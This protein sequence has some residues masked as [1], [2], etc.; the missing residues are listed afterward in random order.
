MI[1]IN[2]AKSI[3]GFIAQSIGK[4]V[5]FIFSIAA[6]SACTANVKQVSQRFAMSDVD[7]TYLAKL[8]APVTLTQS[9]TKSGF[10]LMHSG[11]DALASIIYLSN[12]A[13]KSLDLQY[14][15]FHQDRSG[16]LVMYHLLKAADRGVKVRLLLDDFFVGG[17]NANFDTLARHPNIE[18]KL[19]NPISRRKWLRSFS[20]L[21]NFKIANRR[22]HNK[23]FIAD[24][25][26]AI[27]GGRN[28]G[29]AYYMAKKRYFYRDLDLLAIGSVVQKVSSSFDAY[30]NAKWAVDI[31]KVNKR[32]IFS[33][34]YRNKRQQ[35]AQHYA[36]VK[37]SAYWRHVLKSTVVKKLHDA[38]HHFVWAP[39]KVLYDPPSKVRRFRK[40]NRQYIEYLM[41]QHM[42]Q[43]KSS[44]KIISPYFVP[45]WSGMRWIKQLRKKGVDI[46]V[47]TNS[48]AANDFS[49]S[50]GAY[51]RYRIELLKAGVKLYEFKRGALQETRKK[52]TW[53][54]KK[55]AS[56]LHAKSIIIDD[57]FVYVGSVNYT[58][59]SKLLNT[60]ISIMIDSPVIASELTNTF[61]RLS[62]NS[63]SY[64]LALKRDY[65]DFEYDEEEQYSVVWGANNR[66]TEPEVGFLKHLSISLLSL[67]PIEN[68]L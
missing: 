67:L 8:L 1:N 17:G 30:W 23:V 40:R 49:L 5:I 16:K 48:F 31:K 18:V 20:M 7:Q 24:N 15:S 10:M 25:R 28:I 52:I 37:E 47:L 53:F 60:E 29:D 6:L 2:R 46:S 58:P 32:I 11:I 35:L 41:T 21:I 9:S 42:K 39:Y 12:T 45:Q 4:A 55:P 61:A 22:M 51:Q 14:W 33:I 50:H 62:N 64:Q 59:R 56:Y 38:T 68:L 13:E 19:Y 43:A 34:V 54:K 44:V 63:N 27:V 3:R 66:T 57:R 26:V 65:V 36:R